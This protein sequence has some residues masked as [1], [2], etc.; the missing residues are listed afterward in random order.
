MK[1]RVLYTL[2]SE[3]VRNVDKYAQKIRKG[4]TSGFV[5]DAIEAYVALLTKKSE[6][7]R[8]RESYVLV[9]QDNEKTMREWQVADVEFERALDEIKHEP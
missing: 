5:A 1:E 3:A 6:T 4:D 2:P 7:N 8:L 9:T